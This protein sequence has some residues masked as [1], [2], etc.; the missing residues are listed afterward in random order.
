MET[1]RETIKTLY[2]LWNSDDVIKGVLNLE[3][4]YHSDCQ[5]DR[6]VFV[7]TYLDDVSGIRTK[8]QIGEVYALLDTNWLLPVNSK[9]FMCGKGPTVFNVLLHFSTKVLTEYKRQPVCRYEHLLRWHDLCSMLG[10][11]LLTVSYFAAK[12]LTQKYNRTDFAWKDIIDHDNNAL[13]VMFE[14]PMIDLHSH[15]YGSTFVFDVNWLC[16]MNDV[17]ERK[18]QCDVFE[19]YLDSKH[20][21][22][23]SEQ[24]NSPYKRLM[25]GAAIRI[26]LYWY[27]NGN[28][29]AE[30][31][32]GLKNAVKSVLMAGNELAM[33]EAVK[34][35]QGYIEL[36][37]HAY[38]FPYDDKVGAADV[39]DYAICH[40]IMQGES[41]TIGW[42][43]SILG[44]ERYLMYRMFSKI[45][46]GDVDA[47]MASLFYAYLIIKTDFRSQII[48]LNDAVGYANFADYQGRKLSFLKENSKWK[49]VIEQIA[50]GS[51]VAKEGRYLE[52]RISPR[53]SEDALA[54]SIMNIDKHVTDGYLTFNQN[55][56]KLKNK[57]H[58]IIHFK[59]GSDDKGDKNPFE[60]GAYCRHQRLRKDIKKQACALKSWLMGDDGRDRIVGIDAASSE[61]YCRPEVFGQ[62]YRYLKGYKTRQELGYTFHVGEDFLDVVD[63]LR[64]IRECLLFLNLENRDRVGHALVLGI[65]V[66]QYYAKRNYSV[67]LSKQLLLDNVVW[68]YY[69]G[70]KCDG[71]NRVEVELRTLFQ[72]CFDEVY[73]ASIPDDFKWGI[74]MEDYYHSW[75]LR[76]DNPKLYKFDEEIQNLEDENPFWEMYGMSDAEE[77]IVARNN[78]KAR[79]LFYLY[80]FDQGV[81]ARGNKRESFEVSF[82]LIHVIKQLQEN[83][84]QELE[85]KH[86]A[87]ETNP[88]SNYRICDIN[89]Y[90]EHPILHF[91]NYGLEHD[92]IESHAITVSINTDDK[93]VFATSIEREFSVMAAALEKNYQ[94]THLGNSPRAIYDWLDR[95]RV[96]GFEM[97][98]CK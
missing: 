41:G 62:V 52:S 35:L 88:T 96:M 1:L 78:P 94:K 84:L 57:Y 28:M 9:S 2:H 86:I 18:S 42:L 50:I 98:F 83:L 91:F 76:S 23:A 60:A 58:Y 81:Y 54:K 66:E 82:D 33:N 15:L 45:Y 3:S 59:K 14:K 47:N 71:F 16:L 85:E 31:F 26:L 64:A 74:T 95:I 97:R 55:A 36:A 25:E 24:I 20:L 12:D 29:G 4:P 8:D 10:E 90:D 22:V 80:E 67:A 61:I 73:A 56:D 79:L 38:G 11:D 27:L 63:G 51:S 13:N 5:V 44:G 32:A 48:Q 69:E 53:N 40:D 39:L 93:G 43:Y 49:R 7:R 19:E 92:G 6:K 72:R 37:Q 21:Q 46:C 34:Q 17:L 75:F 87:I 68:L 65:N 70:S 30:Q 77:C 89:R